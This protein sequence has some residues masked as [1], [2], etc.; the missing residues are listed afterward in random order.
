M[1]IVLLSCLHQIEGYLEMKL[2]TLSERKV[3]PLNVS[4][5]IVACINLLE[6]IN[7]W[8]LNS[9]N[10]AWMSPFLQNCS[11]QSHWRYTSFWRFSLGAPLL[12]GSGEIACFFSLVSEYSMLQA[13]HVV[14]SKL[15]KAS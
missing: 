11:P 2:N 1:N 14:A 3:L 8:Q 7:S 4:Q 12:S 6:P 10:V 5:W 9:S 13:S 15:F